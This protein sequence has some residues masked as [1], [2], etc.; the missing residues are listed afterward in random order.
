MQHPYT[1]AGYA[2]AF[3]MECSWLRGARTHILKRPIGDSARIDAMG[4]YPIFVFD[5]DSRIDQDWAQLRNE[6]VVSLVVVTDCLTQPDREFLERHFDICR[7]YKT[8]YGYDVGLPGS[9]YSKH[10]RDRIRRARKSCETRVIELSEYLDEWTLC[11][12]NLVAKKGLTGLQ[13]FPRAYFEGIANMS[14]GVTTVAA[15]A[16]EEFA[17]AHIWFHDER[18]VYA[19]LAAST[20][21]GYKLRCAFAVYDHAIQLF[22]AS[23]VLDFG[24]GAGV[25]PGETDG[26]SEFK[27]GFSNFQRQNYLCGKILDH[28]GYAD[29][30]LRAGVDP[31]T[32]AFFPAYRRPA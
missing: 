1:S 23:H 12:G 21:T 27:K 16:G 19:H 15:F 3:G 26:L 11:Y 13:A 2:A 18:N 30:C 8:H 10:H 6:G 25:E 32:T 5:A 22:K 7:P 4:C 14:S 28:D 29:T 31:G 17:S 24:G 20:E 9:D